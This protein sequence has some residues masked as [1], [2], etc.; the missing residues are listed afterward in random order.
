MVEVAAALV[1][2][3]AVVVVIA[4]TL[5]GSPPGAVAVPISKTFMS[6]AYPPSLVLYPQDASAPSLEA[7]SAERQ[8]EGWG[9]IDAIYTVGMASCAQRAAIMQSVGSHMGLPLTRLEATPYSEVNLHHPP[10]P[11]V[12]I[13]AGDSVAAGQV[14]CA[15]THV[16][17]WRAA[18]AANYSRVLVLED[19]VFFSP[20]AVRHIP[21]VLATADAGAVAA[22]RPWHM[23]LFRRTPLADTSQEQ[24]WGEDKPLGGP[25]TVT[26]PAWATAAYAL[27]RA[28]MHYLLSQVTSYNVP[29]DV[30]ISRLHK[31]ET[32]FTSL[33]ACN[34]QVDGSACVDAVYEL[35]REEKGECAYSGSQSGSRE[36]G[37]SFPHSGGRRA[38]ALL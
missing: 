27:S 3:A 24:T 9:N 23:I 18:L 1:A 21:A 17:L 29:L 37:G 12:D 16:R 32:G 13:P 19:D 6:V 38:V 35:N 10:L 8:S 34:P 30:Q 25:L 26:V 15:H 22:G 33:A 11:I 31:P 14:G 28:G 4:V 36:D 2:A 5:L 20:Q 7:R